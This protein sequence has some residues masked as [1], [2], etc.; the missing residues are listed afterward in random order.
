MCLAVVKSYSVFIGLASSNSFSFVVVVVV[1]LF[2]FCF[3]LFIVILLLLLLCPLFFLC[4]HSDVY[5]VSDQHPLDAPEGK[6]NL[7]FSHAS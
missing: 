7:A 1:L 3:C 2:L 5:K 6:R 4:V